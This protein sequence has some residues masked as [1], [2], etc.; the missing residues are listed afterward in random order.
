MIQIGFAESVCLF[1]STGYKYYN[2]LFADLENQKYVYKVYFDTYDWKSLTG[3][4]CFKIQHKGT[5]L[6]LNFYSKIQAYHS[7]AI[8]IY[9]FNDNFPFDVI[10]YFTNNVKKIEL[11]NFPTQ[12]G[13]QADYLIYLQNCKE[14]DNLRFEIND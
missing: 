11:L 13:Q 1:G 6:K 10:F 9:F 12:N 4:D 2:Y 3:F 5:N 14:F 7:T 8:H